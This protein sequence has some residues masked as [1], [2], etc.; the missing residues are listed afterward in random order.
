MEITRLTESGDVQLKSVLQLMAAAVSQRQ[1]VYF[2]WKNQELEAKL[3]KIHTKLMSSGVTV[4]QLWN[5]LLN[6]YVVV[7]DCGSKELQL[8]EYLET[9]FS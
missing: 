6:Y 1:L 8:F 2:T 4:G 3:K 9:T 5:C 7:N